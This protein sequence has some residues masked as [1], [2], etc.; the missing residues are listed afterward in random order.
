MS[1]SILRVYWGASPESFA[2]SLRFI[3]RQMVSS[4]VM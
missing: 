3:S 4:M 1:F 2:F